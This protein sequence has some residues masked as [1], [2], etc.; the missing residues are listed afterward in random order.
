MDNEV[1]S[2]VPLQSLELPS[3]EELAHLAL[4]DP[5]SYEALRREL[6]DSFIDQAPVTYKRRLL[7]VQFRVDNVRLLSRSALGSTV[8]VYQMMC[9]ILS[10]LNDNWQDLNH[11]DDY[12]ANNPPLSAAD[13]K[14]YD[15]R[16]LE[17]RPSTANIKNQAGDSDERLS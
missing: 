5:S 9:E 4:N 10:Q 11:L 7:G 1:N 3:H 13:Y 17:F 2:Q 12:L 6:I 14:T 15:A 8:K 16:I